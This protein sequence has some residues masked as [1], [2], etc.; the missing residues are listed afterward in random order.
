MRIPNTGLAVVRSQLIGRL[1]DGIRLA[2]EATQRAPIH[3]Y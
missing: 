1:R 3:L 2:I